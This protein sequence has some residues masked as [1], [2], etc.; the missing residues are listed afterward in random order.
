MMITGLVGGCAASTTGGIK[1]V[2]GLIIYKHGLREMKRLLHPKIVSPLRLGSD[3]L[4][5]GLVETVR[6]FM[7]I[8][9]MIFIGF[10]LLLVAFGL[11]FESAFGA[12]I[13]CMANVGAS[14]GDVFDTFLVIQTPAKWILIFAMLM[15]RLELF[16]IL[17]LFSP[18]FWRK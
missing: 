17:V 1:F 8:F 18:A 14:I 11:D 15:G 6:G 7:A 2:R 12:T 3:A 10:I 4:S 9:M 13:A 16:T 5:D